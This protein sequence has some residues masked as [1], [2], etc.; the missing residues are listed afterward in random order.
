MRSII[1]LLKG[2][3]DVTRSTQRL[4]EAGLP[5][6]RISV[7][8]QENAIRKIL[9]CEPTCVVSRYAV[10]GASIGIAVY[11]LFA[12]FA[13]LCQCNLLH[14]G[15]AF[16]FGTFLGGI[17]AG[18]I[19][20]GGLGALVGAAEFEQDSHLYV[21]G[22]RMGGRV[23]VIQASEADADRVKLILEQEKALGVKA[24]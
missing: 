6:D 10:W 18:T 15:Q 21:Q 3:S 9:G 5:E 19:V 16:G 11:A 22:A 14:F 7:F 4:K 13:G 12:L 20:G 23:I 17:L 24:L 2:E 8:T 1:G